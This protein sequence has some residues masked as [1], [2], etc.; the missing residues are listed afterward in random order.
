MIVNINEKNLTVQNT[1]ECVTIFDSVKISS[2]KEM[3]EVLNVIKEQTPD[4]NA[5]IFTRS[6]F[7]LIME[8]RAHNLLY[9]LTPKSKTTLIERLKHVDLEK[10]ISWSLQMCYN[11]IGLFYF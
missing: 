8:W 7:S 10:N 1:T 3:K 5:A 2:W 9:H 4:K 11:I 6:M